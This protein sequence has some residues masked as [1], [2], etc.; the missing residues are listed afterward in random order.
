MD[1]SGTIEAAPAQEVST[2]D[3][4]A[5]AAPER[6]DALSFYDDAPKADPALGTQDETAEGEQ[7]ANE[8][9]QTAAAAAIARP[10][11]WGNDQ[12]EQ[13]KKLG[14]VDPKLQEWLAT[15]ETDREKFV[16]SK[17]EEVVATRRQAEAQ[18][19]DALVQAQNAH[20]ER[21]EQMAQLVG[22]PQP[23]NPALLNSQDPEDHRLYMVQQN[24]YQATV[25]QV[26]QLQQSAEQARQQ[27][28]SLQSHAEREAIQADEAKL[29]EQWPDW[30][31]PA[32]KAE[33]LARLAPIA[34]ELGYS[35]EAQ[36][37]ANSSDLL[38]LDKIASWKEDAVKYRNLMKQRMEP[39]RAARQVPPAMRA[40]APTN[41]ARHPVD[42]SAVLYPD[43]QPRR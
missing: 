35:P 41:G 17:A 21:I 37:G 29:V 38:A 4:G 33:R 39:V 8:A 15:R 43:D 20:A 40:A 26:A 32:K 12:N 2:A 11:S 6:S 5:P 3:T 24:R 27:A 28:L 10:P 7:Q 14:Q 42:A 34:T 30:S 9:E 22:I 16:R 25:A 1:M 31:D 13:W 19:R 36:A 23:P 18:A